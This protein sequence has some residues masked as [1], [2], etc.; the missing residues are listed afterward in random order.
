M[1]NIGLTMT[2]AILATACGRPTDT[3]P[4]ADEAENVATK[5]AVIGTTDTVASAVPVNAVFWADVAGSTYILAAAGI[6]GLEIYTMDGRRA[7]GAPTV[8]AGMVAL[9]PGF[10]LGGASVPLVIVYDA[11]TSTTGA[12][13]FEPDSL[14]LR[15]VMDVP[16]AVPDELTGLCQY[17]SRL[18]GSDYLY[19]ATD[20]G[21]IFHFELY[22]SEGKVAANLLRTIPSGKGSGFCAVDARDS[23]LYV[24]EE[25][26]GIWRYGAEPESDTTRELIDVRAPWGSLG[27]DLKG[28]AIY[29]VDA[30]LSYLLAADAAE[31]LVLVYALPAGE[32]LGSFVI[33]GLGEPEG[34]AATTLTFG[35]NFPGGALAIADEATSGGGPNLKLLAWSTLATA[36][37]LRSATAE[38][39]YPQPV[40]V[41][42]RVETE[43]M[44]SFGDAADDPAI[45]V[46]PDDPTLSL[47]IGTNKQAGLHVYDLEGKTLQVLPDGKM[48]NVD[49]RYDF[50]LGGDKVTLVTASNRSNDSIAAYRIDAA[51]RRLVDIAAGVLP[52]GF[53][54]P[55][56]LCMYRSPT[57]GHFFVFVNESEQGMF[58]QWRLFDDGNGKVTVEQV[59]EFVVGTQAEG[60]VADD[61]TGML[62]VAEEDVG[63]W[64][65]S[66]GPDG[67]DARTLIDGIEDGRLTDDVE[68]MALWTGTGGSGYLVVSNQGAD[69]YALYRREGDNAYVGHFHIVANAAAGIDG[70]SE[71]DG[72]DVSSTALGSAYPDGL[73]VVQDGRNIAPEEPQNFKFVSWTDV[74]LALQLD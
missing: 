26:T 48:N 42:P 12:Y 13:V 8:D 58:R 11:A 67:G 56:G 47:V 41:Q 10:R 60:C 34:L 33:D 22:E 32:R 17:R 36:A 23:M 40:V 2:L 70:A 21:L 52:T 3:G 15:S 71:T 18:S 38:A 7:G 29:P 39:D 5:V 1:R 74:K 65:Y 30:E 46:H 62:Y 44:P 16:I 50:P 66:A 64:K 4:A 68:G 49:L 37:G 35:G 20:S 69:N 6:A 59:R 19:A 9:L 72:L 14:A 61:E 45:W 31:G 28:I 53:H 51:A 24:S 55:Y 43:V 57:S 25:S 63:V 27:D 54:D 73:L